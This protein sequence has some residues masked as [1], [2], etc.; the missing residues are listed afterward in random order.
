MNNST[1]KS[2]LAT[3]KSV[4]AS[5]F[6]VFTIFF[7]KIRKLKKFQKLLSE[8]EVQVQVLYLLLIIVISTFIRQLENSLVQY[9]I[10]R[11]FTL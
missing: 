2:K 1:S 10:I 11:L 4:S 3:K 5:Q 8:K 9:M 6:I 7:L